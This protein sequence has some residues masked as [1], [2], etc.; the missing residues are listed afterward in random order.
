ML[1]LP[2]VASLRLGPNPV[3]KEAYYMSGAGGQTTMITRRTISSWSA[4]AT[5]RPRR[6][7]APASGGRWRS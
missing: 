5:T 4:S 6:T 2:A 7:G 3:P 1:P